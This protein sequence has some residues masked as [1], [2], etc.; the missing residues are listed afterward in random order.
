VAKD[1]DLHSNDKSKNGQHPPNRDP[2]PFDSK[3]RDRNNVR[4]IDSAKGE[5]EDSW[6]RSWPGSSA[7]AG[8]AVFLLGIAILSA[9][10]PNGNDKKSPAESSKSN[11]QLRS[12]PASQP[13]SPVNSPL[14][15]SPTIPAD[16]ARPKSSI[17]PGQGPNAVSN[18]PG[19]SARHYSPMRYEATQKAVF[20]GCS[21]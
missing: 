15:P 10:Y 14:K 11:E 12:G 18:L 2:I 13:S 4:P 16:T 9:L 19:F 1:F 20:R 17:M 6:P 21:S 5:F 7:G 8:T 3:R